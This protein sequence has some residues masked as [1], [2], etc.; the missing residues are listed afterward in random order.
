MPST[1]TD[2]AED[3]LHEST[4]RGTMVLAVRKDVAAAL[5]G[6]DGE[7]VPLIV[8]ALGRLHVAAGIDA[9]AA[10]IAKAEDAPHASGD[11][12]VFILGVRNDAALTLAGT[13]GDYAPIAVGR[14]GGVLINP[15]L[16]NAG[17]QANANGASVWSSSLTGATFPAFA[18]FLH[19][20]STRD[21]QT[22]NQ[23]LTLLAS[24]AR[25]AS[26]N[27]PDQTNYNARGVVV[28]IDATALAATPSVVF[29]IEGMAAP[30]V[31]YPILASAAVTGV[32]RTVLVV[33]P[34][35]AEAA[36][37]KASHPLPRFW[38]VSAVAADADSLTYAVY[39]SQ[40][41]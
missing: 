17:L 29:T 40:I 12:G 10:T 2:Y 30:G 18:P 21:I 26:T 5:A 13:D 15:E 37:A 9:G 36:N 1:S 16:S 6:A 27:S 38:R 34:G 20:G 22:N 3:S 4:D 31:Y 14:R 11:T 23:D 8:D 19:N 24:A 35:I 33:Y 7:Y 39:A 41:L 32:S 25:T 28:V